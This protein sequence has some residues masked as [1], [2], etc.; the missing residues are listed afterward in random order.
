MEKK[1]ILSSEFESIQVRTLTRSLRVVSGTWNEELLKVDSLRLSKS[2]H[3]LTR[4]T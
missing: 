2:I 4:I 1:I 3:V